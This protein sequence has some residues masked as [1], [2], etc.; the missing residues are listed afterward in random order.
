MRK[1]RIALIG[2]AGAVAQ[3][4]IRDLV[5]RDAL[6]VAAFGNRNHLGEDI[7]TIAGIDPVGVVLSPRQK[8]AEILEQT[9]PDVAIDCTFNELSRAFEHVKL[10]MEHGVSILHAGVFC[11][12]PQ[13]SDPELVAELDTIGKK[14]NCTFLG[15]SSGELWQLL[16]AVLSTASKRVTEIKLGFYALLDDFGAECARAMGVGWTME[17]WANAPCNDEGSPWE[18]VLRLL[19]DQLGLH[20]DDLEFKQIPIPALET[21]NH[22]KLGMRIEKGTAMGRDEYAILR[23]QEGITIT[24]VC[25]C[26][27]ADPSETH[28]YEIEVLGEPDFR[29]KVDD[30]HGEYATSTIMVNRLPDLMKAPRGVITINEMPAPTNK[31]ASAYYTE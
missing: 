26:K 1:I 20:A 21:I 31:L 18:Q 15:S 16:P 22:E 6:I 25:H 12:Y 23:T 28:A 7:G 2:A 11:Y 5:A 8:M 3:E 9:K 24:S 27:V 29:M 13:V 19:A 10:C 4:C 14:N 30:F 17:Q